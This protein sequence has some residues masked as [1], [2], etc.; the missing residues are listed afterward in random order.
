MYSLHKYGWS[1]YSQNEEDGVISYILSK[2][3]DC[4]RYCVEFGAWDGVNFSNTYRLVAEEGYRALL[5]EANATRF[6]A[7]LQTQKKHPDQIIARQLMLATEGERSLDNILAKE[8]APQDMDLLSIDIDSFDYQ[9]WDS[10]KQYR[11]KIVIIEYNPCYLPYIRHIHGEKHK[12]RFSYL[13]PYVGSSLGSMLDLCAR[14]GYT[15][16]HLSSC[17]V[18]AVENSLL[19][20]LQPMPKVAPWRRWLWKH[21]HG[22]RT[23]RGLRWYKIGLKAE[24]LGRKVFPFT[25][26]KD[27]NM[28]K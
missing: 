27:P 11:P 26:D 6:E 20:H 4:N 24:L 13:V 18:I 7:L 23:L 12:S 21:I 22:L 9:I 10:L 25:T 2:L 8:Q 14:K 5:I 28:E 1:K 19:S 3:P 17:N 16:V 15:L